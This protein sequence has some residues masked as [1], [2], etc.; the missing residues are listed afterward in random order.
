MMHGTGTYI[1]SCSLWTLFNNTLSV[2]KEKIEKDPQNFRWK[3]APLKIIHA[4]HCFIFIFNGNYIVC[5][6]NGYQQ[7]YTGSNEKEFKN[8]RKEFASLQK[9]VL[10][11]TVLRINRMLP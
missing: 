1:N 7:H 5:A 11:A 10:Q 9:K 2:T 3:N 4:R 8:L 6:V